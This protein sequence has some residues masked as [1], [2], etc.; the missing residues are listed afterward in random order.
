MSRFSFIEQDLPVLSAKMKGV[1]G[2]ENISGEIF[3]YKLEKGLCLYADFTGLPALQYLPFH[4]HE[5]TSC[6]NAG[7][8][9]L[10]FPDVMSDSSG[11]ASTHYCFDKLSVSEISGRAIVLHRKVGENEPKIACGILKFI[12]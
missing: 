5:G 6:E 9:L 3:V 8:H 2:Y 4:I 7:G 11:N 12:A 10:E 1:E